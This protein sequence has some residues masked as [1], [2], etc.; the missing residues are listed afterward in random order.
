M[1]KIRRRVSDKLLEGAMDRSLDARELEQNL[2]TV[3]SETPGYAVAARAARSAQ[4]VESALL[5]LAWRLQPRSTDF[6]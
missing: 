1:Q 6:S 3:R 5:W 2:L 4:R